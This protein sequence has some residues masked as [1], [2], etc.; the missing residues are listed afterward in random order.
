MLESYRK[1]GSTHHVQNV[2]MNVLVFFIRFISCASC[3]EYASKRC[4]N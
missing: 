1:R 2:S 3:V 4:K